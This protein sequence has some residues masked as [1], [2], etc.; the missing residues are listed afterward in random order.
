M[1]SRPVCFY[2]FPHG[3][4]FSKVVIYKRSTLSLAHCVLRK[5]VSDDLMDGSLLKQLM[6]ILWANPSQR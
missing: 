6:S 1:R 2:H 3:L 5:N 4:C